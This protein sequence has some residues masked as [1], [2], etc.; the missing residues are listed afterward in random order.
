MKVNWK[1]PPLNTEA[2]RFEE[3]TDCLSQSRRQPNT[4]CDLT[5]II[6]YGRPGTPM[7]PWGVVGG[8][9]KN[10]QSIADLVAYI[11]SIQLSPRGSRRQQAADA[12]RGRE[13]DDPKRRR[14]RST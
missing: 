14:A 9:P 2:L 11:E 3:D 1:V 13:S 12:L 6:T 4:I 5:D 10:D 8:G 7:Q